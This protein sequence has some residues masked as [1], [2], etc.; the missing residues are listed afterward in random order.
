MAEIIAQTDRLLLR[1]EAPGDLE[2]WLEHINVPQVMAMLGG[3]QKEA[4]V[5]EAFKRMGQA[6]SL[7]HPSFFFVAL[8]ADN[9]LIGKCGL[10]LIETPCAPPPLRGAIQ[11]GWT[12]RAEH[13]GRG[14][15][16]EAARV[17]LSMA[18]E[19][20]DAPIVYAQTS[21]R[22]VASWRVM[23]KLGMERQAIHDYADPDYP[24]EDNPTMVWAIDRAGWLARPV[25]VV[26]GRS[27]DRT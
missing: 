18:F 8:R 11:I 16:L 19:R 1:G 13:W 22:N 5:V 12:L 10:A 27:R 24:P 17:A 6:I 7:G 14:Y 26:A 15:A 2:L 25:D 3:P 21:E 4:D 20:H 9:L 23:A